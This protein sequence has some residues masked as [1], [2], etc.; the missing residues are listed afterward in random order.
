[1]KRFSTRRSNR[2][3]WSF[4]LVEMLVAVAV[5]SLMIAAMAQMSLLVSSAWIQGT[6][7]IDDFTKS[8]AMLD[9]VIQDL[10][11]GV[12]RSD[13]PSFLTGAQTLSANGSTYFENGTY[14]N[15]FYT[16]VPG[17]DPGVGVRDVSLV[18]YSLNTANQGSDKIS[19]QRSELAVPWG[20]SSATNIAFGS[21]ASLMNLMQ[22]AT[23]QA[24]SP[25]I[26]GFQVLFRRQDGS[27]IPSSGYTGED[28]THGPVV[29]IGVG[30]ALVGK[31]AL[32]EM[33]PTQVSN[34]AGQIA[35]I[36]VTTS[37]KAA[38]DQG[39][40][41]TILSQYP[42]SLSFSFQ[43]FERWVACQPF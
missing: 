37:A 7:R 26:V 39:V 29:A 10:Q 40:Y 41:S 8:R 19:L 15:A 30:I 23:P 25:G 4:T 1:M 36:T 14:T 24:A 22:Y 13:I 35:A 6:N 38:W 43:T 9:L 32:T 11:R 33:T 2:H 3:Y 42:R 5:L 20:P 31:Q 16:R 12:F 28:L 18:S 17:I 34:F 27:I 21:D